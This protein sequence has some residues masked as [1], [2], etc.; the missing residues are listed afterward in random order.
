MSLRSRLDK[1][2][3]LPHIW[4]YN[5]FLFFSEDILNVYNVS[6]MSK[7]SNSSNLGLR[8]IQSHKHTSHR[9]EDSSFKQYPFVFMRLQC[10]PAILIKSHVNLDFRFPSLCLAAVML[11]LSCWRS[12]FPEPVASCRVL[13]SLHASS[14][15]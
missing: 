13:R 8:D 9:K 1:L 6:S 14:R 7:L 4:S 12:C 2:D 15:S 11:L 5:S 3:S 10:S